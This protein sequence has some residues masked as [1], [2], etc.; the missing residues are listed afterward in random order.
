MAFE[1]K[2]PEWFA[3]GIEP[4]ASLKQ[5]GFTA[6]YKPPAEYFNWFW[7]G[8]SAVLKELQNMSPEDIGA[9][10]DS[11]VP[12]EKGGTGKASVTSGNFLVGN[13]TNAMNERT[14]AQ[15][16]E[17][18]NA[19]PTDHNHNDLYYTEEAVNNKL[20]G[21]S[22]TT[23]THT[24]PEIGAI[25]ADNNRTDIPNGSDLDSDEFLKVGAWRA[26]TVAVASSILNCP[27]K[28]AFTMDVVAGTGFHTEVK[29][30]SGYIIQKITTNEGNQHFRRIYAGSNGRIFD[31]WEKVYSTQ[32][33]PTPEEIGA[34]KENHNHRTLLWTNSDHT[35]EFAPQ[36]V[37]IS[38]L[39]GYSGVEI[40]FTS[41]AKEAPLWST[42]FVPYVTAFTHILE[43]TEGAASGTPVL[44][45]RQW[46]MKSNGV[47]FA[48]GLRCE[49]GKTTFATANTACIP[50]KIYGI[51]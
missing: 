23:H 40:L 8:V 17:A 19:A 25:P 37:S 24:A 22:D 49:M 34:A 3:G 43:G 41:N 32:Q 14:P 1:K 45:K 13:G 27:V 50:W 28:V 36:T 7:S 31:G 39:G 38:A 44:A 12:V 4:P 30:N 10:A 5:S 11:V 48:A 33:K 18:I 6:G 16:R 47:Q 26:T 21:K 2:V 51:E 9:L 42:G 29:A 46:S 20:A 15:V 35:A